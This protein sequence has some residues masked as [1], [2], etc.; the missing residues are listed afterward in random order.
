MEFT[1][2]TEQI[3]LEGTC[4][5]HL[6]Q[7]SAPSRANLVITLLMLVSKLGYNAQSAVSLDKSEGRIEP[8]GGTLPDFSQVTLVCLDASGLTVLRAE[9]SVLGSPFSTKMILSPIQYWDV[10]WMFSFQD[11]WK[12]GYLLLVV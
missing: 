11:T 3:R 5:G 6:V 7:T 9:H 8:Q 1:N 2:G 4:G 10:A 12:S